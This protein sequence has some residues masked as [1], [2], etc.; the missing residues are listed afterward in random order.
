MFAKRA[1]GVIHSLGR[2]ASGKLKR[3]R[4]V[5]MQFCALVWEF[6]HYTDITPSQSV[7]R[8]AQAKSL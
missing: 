2:V 8:R 1:S 3:L 4:A 7:V 5:G 6:D